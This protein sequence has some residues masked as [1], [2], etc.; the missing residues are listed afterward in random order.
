MAES[1]KTAANRTVT[2]VQS[3]CVVFLTTY[4]AWEM[5][6]GQCAHLYCKDC[7]TRL[8]NDALAD[9]SLFPPQ[10]C[11]LPIPPYALRKH[12]GAELFRRFEEKEIENK[13]PFRTYCFNSQCS[14]YIQPTCVKGYVGSC[15]TCLAETC[16]LCKRAAHEGPCIDE[17]DKVLRLAEQHGWQRCRQ[18]HHL[19][20]LATGRN[21]IT[22]RCRYEFCYVCLVK[23]KQCRCANW[24]ENRLYDRAQ[25]VAARS[26]QRPAEPQQAQA[27]QEQQAQQQQPGPWQV[28]A[29]QDVERVAA[30]I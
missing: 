9:Q 28:P 29:R 25:V 21:H 1:S 30:S 27:A 8:V 24:D 5:V 22:C 18:C 16:T 2:E 15:Q 11:R 14:K 19:I 23:W 10:C 4:P 20:E 3:E 12:L 6:Q 7:M 26:A 17:L 13:D